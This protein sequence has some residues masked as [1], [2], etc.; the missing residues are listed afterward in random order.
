MPFVI[1]QTFVMGFRYLYLVFVIHY[2]Y[3]V[4]H[5]RYSKF[6]L[7]YHFFVLW[8]ITNRMLLHAPLVTEKFI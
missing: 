6:F 3:F 4:I 7:E 8:R 1:Y 2:L 5:M